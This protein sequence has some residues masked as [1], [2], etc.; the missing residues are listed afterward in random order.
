MEFVSRCLF[1]IEELKASLAA[2]EAERYA[3]RAE[4]AAEESWRCFQCGF[5]TTEYEKAEAHF[6]D[7]DEDMALCRWWKDSTD[8]ERVQALQDAIEE[9]NV[10]RTEA[11]RAVEAL[12][13]VRGSIDA[14]W[15][16]C[17]PQ[18]QHDLKT[19]MDAIEDAM[20]PRGRQPAI[21]WLAQQR[22]EAAAEALEK[23]ADEAGGIEELIACNIRDLRSALRTRAAAIRAGEVPHE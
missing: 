11:A 9:Q 4:A 20:F 1:K 8:T 10:A 16:Y 15:N 18:V 14:A 12:W 2:V 6:G 22:A 13:I 5:Y 21:A 23:F 7:R 3:A 17:T 19:A